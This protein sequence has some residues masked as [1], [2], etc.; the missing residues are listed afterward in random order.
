MGLLDL[1][2]DRCPGCRRKRLRMAS[3]LQWSGRAPDGRRTGGCRTYLACLT[4][5]ARWVHEL[6]APPQPCPDDEWARVV[7]PSLPGARLR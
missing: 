4:C 3:A 5:G 6:D 1:F 7:G 2:R